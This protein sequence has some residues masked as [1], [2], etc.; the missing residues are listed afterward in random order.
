ML[1]NTAL[2]GS[3]WVDD[4]QGHPRGRVG[5]AWRTRQDARKFA[6]QQG[7]S[8]EQALQIG[9]EHEAKE[10]AKRGSEIYAKT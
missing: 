2:S 4:I 10:F 9:L 1:M 7:I 3:G 5:P 8:E 6:P